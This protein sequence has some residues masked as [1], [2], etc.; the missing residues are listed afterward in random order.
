MRQV[1]DKPADTYGV[2][3]YVIPVFFLGAAALSV[4]ATIVQVIRERPD[5]YDREWARFEATLERVRQLPDL[6]AVDSRRVQG[7]I[8][9]LA[10]NFLACI[11]VASSV[12]AAAW[13]FEPSSATREGPTTGFSECEMTT[14]G[15][16]C[17]EEWDRLYRE[18][19]QKLEPYR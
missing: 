19:Q 17:R 11:L 14:V 2:E 9:K 1:S 8:D 7:R 15:A 3:D 10:N 4:V 5:A 18:R 6:R 13:A 12:A 16:P